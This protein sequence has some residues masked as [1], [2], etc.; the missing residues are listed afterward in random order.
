[1]TR[2]EAIKQATEI[3]NKERITMAVVLEGPHRDEHA[4]ADSHGFCPADAVPVLYRYGSIKDVI[5]PQPRD[6]GAVRWKVIPCPEHGGKHTF[7]D[8]RYI[9]TADAEVE[10]DRDG[11]WR[12]TKGEI[13][14]VMRDGPPENA[15]LAAAAPRLLA[16]LEDA[17]PMLFHLANGQRTTELD[18]KMAAIAFEQARAA[19]AKAK[20]GAP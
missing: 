15:H 2:A 7:H 13:I 19:I 17:A 4:P 11:T 16:A 5:K 12:L 1:M 9:V 8:H 18:V 14:C 6:E 3:A 10:V 20:G